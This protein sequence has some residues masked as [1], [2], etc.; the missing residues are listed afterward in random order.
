MKTPSDVRRET[1]VEKLWREDGGHR[2][3]P[4]A[5]VLGT[6]VLS[7]RKVMNLTMAAGWCCAMTCL[8]VQVRSWTLSPTWRA[9]W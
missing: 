7:Q 9:W 6:S 8:L 5:H 1:K 4:E 3:H 2:D